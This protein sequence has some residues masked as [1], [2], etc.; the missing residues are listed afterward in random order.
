MDVL[1][2]QK[3]F[4]F[5]DEVG[6]IKGLGKKVSLVDDGQ[7]LG[8][9]ILAYAIEEGTIEGKGVEDIYGQGIVLPCRV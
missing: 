6:V 7:S 4:G 2:L 3:L 5:G 9:E 1:L 8:W